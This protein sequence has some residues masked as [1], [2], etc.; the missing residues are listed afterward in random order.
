MVRLLEN[1][2]QLPQRSFS[3]A[4]SAIRAPS[5]A[6]S[7]A[8][9]FTSLNLP[10]TRTDSLSMKTSSVIPC[11]PCKIHLD[12]ELTCVAFGGHDAAELLACGL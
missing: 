9:D 1:E 10:T 5:R 3:R 6:N 4:S 2:Q 7:V 12:D 8:S 11:L